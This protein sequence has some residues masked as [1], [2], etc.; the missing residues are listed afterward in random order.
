MSPKLPVVSGKDAVKKFQKLGYSTT[1]QRGSHIRM[2]D[3][4]DPA[5]KP[6]TVPL[7]D[8]IK[9]GLLRQLLKDANVTIEEFIDL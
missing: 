4:G 9:P 5:H 8:T 2:R 7:H 1:R 6:L 3:A